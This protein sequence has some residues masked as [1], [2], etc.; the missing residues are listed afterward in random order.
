MRRSSHKSWGGILLGIGMFFTLTVGANIPEGKAAQAYYFLSE[1]SAAETCNTTQLLNFLEEARNHLHAPGTLIIDQRCELS[2]PIII[3]PRFTLSGVGIDGEGGLL[4]SN[5]PQGSSAI[6]I[7]TSSATLESSTVP[8]NELCG[9]EPVANSYVT[10]RDLP[11]SGDGSGRGIDLS[12]TQFVYIDRVRL[13]NFGT[14]IYGHYTFSANIT[15]SS[16]LLNHDNI[17][18]ADCT[19]SWRIRDSTISQATR[20]GVVISSIAN[21]HLLDGN[22]MESNGLGAIKNRSSFANLTNNRIEGNGHTNL[23]GTYLGIYNAPTATGIRIIGNLFEGNVISDK[24]SSSVCAF[25]VGPSVNS[26]CQY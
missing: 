21:D 5:L 9:N 8:E 20:W 6:T 18:L 15:H 14:G 7:D 26:K 1:L 12:N 2:T 19:T 13:S 11:I 25:N 17:I 16:V 10:I 24:G 4:F 3:P 23:T 22:R